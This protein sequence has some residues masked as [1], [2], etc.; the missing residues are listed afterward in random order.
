MKKTVTMYVCVSTRDYDAGKISVWD[1]DIS[2][3][4]SL[5]ETLLCTQDVEIEIPEFD[6]VQI[7]VDGI[8]KK[9]ANIR[10]DAQVEINQLNQR[11]QE[12]LAIGHEQ[13]GEHTA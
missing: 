7:Q 2:R 1:T 6:I 5:Q 4:D 13:T 3:V 10:A 11:K 12:L 9:I 8:D